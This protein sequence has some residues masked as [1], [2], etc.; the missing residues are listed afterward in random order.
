MGRPQPDPSVNV[1]VKKMLSGLAKHCAGRRLGNGLLLVLLL[2]GGLFLAW[3]EWLFRQD[4]RVP[5]PVAVTPATPSV[6]FDSTALASVLGFAAATA[7]R[8]TAEPLTLHASVLVSPG[9]SKAL[10]AHAQGARFYL[11]GERLPGG[12]VLRRVASTYV[13]LWNKGRE[14]RLALASS[15]EPFLRRLDPAHRVSPVTASE[16]FLRPFPGRPSN[17]TDE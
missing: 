2:G 8:P 1:D 6:A 4:L 10:L 14:E 9:P 3:R 12:S 15:A 13:V 5:L 17:A 16:R 11:E 7:P